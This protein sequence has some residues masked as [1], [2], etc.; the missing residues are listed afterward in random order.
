MLVTGMENVLG[1]THV[2]ISLQLLL[3]FIRLDYGMKKDLL[4]KCCLGPELAAVL[5]G[6]HCAFK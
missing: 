1:L 2:I 5:L 6:V 3:S 4:G